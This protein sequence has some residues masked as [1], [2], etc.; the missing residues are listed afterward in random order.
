MPRLLITILTGLLLAGCGAVPESQPQVSV[1]V[2][3][4]CAATDPAPVADEPLSL[5]LATYNVLGGTP[6][7]EWFPQIEPAELDPAVREPAT[8]ALIEQL[9]ADVIG[10]QEY[11]PE[12]EPGA[13]MA[14]DLSRYTWVAPDSG[15]P[16]AV[17]VPILY[18][19]SRFDCQASGSERVAAIGE[20][21]SM[22][23]RYVNWV[24][25]QDRDSGRRFFVFNYHAHPWQTEEFA[26]LRSTSISRLVELVE[27][28]NPGHAEPFAILGDFNAGSKEAQPVYRDHLRKLGRAGLADA[29]AIAAEDRS[30]V[31]RAN[32]LNRMS[33]KVRGEPVGK[34][35]RRT[36]Q[37]I[38]YIWVPKGTEVPGWA[39]VT[40]PA[41]TWR[42][43]RGEK[44]PVWTGVVPSDHSPV[45]AELRFTG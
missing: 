35:V 32:S 4:G 28:V 14:A 1:Q 43:I 9:D 41:V 10:L 12:G 29:A 31:P 15:D 27:R 17:A 42:R 21:G 6:P 39:T 45:V 16:E 3:T 11:R 44:V 34:V 25:L 5:T 23:D 18:R 30:N 36:G 33:A 13:R 22:L 8:V 7:P 38:D 40:G 2:D 24:E 26:A 20:D 19:S 37:H